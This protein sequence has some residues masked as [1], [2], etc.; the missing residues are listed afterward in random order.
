MNATATKAAAEFNAMKSNAVIMA[1]VRG[2]ALE[3]VAKDMQSEGYCGTAK[4]VEI[5]A[6]R[7]KNIAKRVDDYINVGLIGCYM[8]KF[9]EPPFL[10][11][12]ASTRKDD[13]G[14]R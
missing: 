3:Q 7:H 12:R 8:A 11:R 6:Y 14:Q 2:E 13:D 10:L 1:F 4:A 9:Q 5:L